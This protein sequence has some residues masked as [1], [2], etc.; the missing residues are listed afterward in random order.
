METGARRGA[1]CGRAERP[2]SCLTFSRHA[3]DQMAGE[4]AEHAMGKEE[5]TGAQHTSLLMRSHGPWRLRPRTHRYHPR[6]AGPPEQAHRRQRAGLG[7]TARPGGPGRPPA[8][9]VRRE[10]A[11]PSKGPPLAWRPGSQRSD[12]RFTPVSSHFPPEVF[13]DLTVT[14]RLRGL[15][16]R[17]GQADS[18]MRLR[19]Q[20]E[21]TQPEIRSPVE[22]RGV[23]GRVTSPQKDVSALPPGLTR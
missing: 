20:P 10:A 15:A 1:P 13:W 8:C 7:E 19:H 16:S 21:R 4:R 12:L 5:W 6:R 9:F 23:A 2:R 17:H 22:E 14:I 11:R 3:G 18:V